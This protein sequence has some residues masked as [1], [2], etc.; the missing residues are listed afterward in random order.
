MRDTGTHGPE[1]T[2]AA[3][4]PEAA[5]CTIYHDGACPLCRAEIALYR[6]MQPDRP[7]EFVDVSTAPPQAQVAADLT[8][9]DAMRRFHVRDPDGRL[10]SGAEAFGLLWR[11]YEGFRWL[12]RLVQVRPIGWIA[13]GAY[14]LFLVTVR[15]LM[16]RVVRWWSRRKAA[17]AG[18][19]SD[20]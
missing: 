13:E 16:Q 8:G 19:A 3:R 12:G 5:A 7:M 2:P 6:R 14:R 11:N 20:A 9:A 4:D 15:P 17:T 1:T 18:Q 10:V